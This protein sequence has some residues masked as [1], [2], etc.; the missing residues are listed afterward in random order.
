MQLLKDW[1]VH[2]SRKCRIFR[3]IKCVTVLPSS[4]SQK[5]ERVF[6]LRMS[7]EGGDL[8]SCVS[9]EMERQKAHF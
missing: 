7:S 9:E 4:P 3:I 8:K 5:S 2:V 1:F 6:L